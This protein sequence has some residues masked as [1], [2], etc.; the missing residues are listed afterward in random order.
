MLSWF[1]AALRSWPTVE[2]VKQDFSDNV[3]WD[4]FVWMKMSLSGDIILKHE[5]HETALKWY[6]SIGFRNV[7]CHSSFLCHIT[8]MCWFNVS[9]FPLLLR[10]HGISHWL[11][12]NLC[13]KHF[14]QCFSVKHSMFLCQFLVFLVHILLGSLLFRYQYQCSWLPGKI[15]LKRL[16]MCRV[17]R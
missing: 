13:A 16:I 6:V 8:A 10:V 9:F 15:R 2:Y 11:T 12:W 3:F 5:T 7:P 17:G 4:I 1:A 14:F